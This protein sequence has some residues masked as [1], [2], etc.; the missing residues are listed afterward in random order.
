M[1]AAWLKKSTRLRRA[2][3]LIIKKPCHFGVVS[4]EHRRWPRASSLIEKETDEHQ[5]VRGRP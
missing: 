2:A 1:N 4:Y 5:R 3:S